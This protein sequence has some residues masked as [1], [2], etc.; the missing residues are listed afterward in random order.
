MTEQELSNLVINNVESQD[1]YDYM[2][3]NYL[4]KTN[5][6][7]LVQ[8]SPWKVYEETTL[9][10]A[11]STYTY[12]FPH[13]VKKARITIWPKAALSQTWRTITINGYTC[14]AM[15]PAIEANRAMMVT[16]DSTRE[17][18]WYTQAVLVYMN[19]PFSNG[20]TASSVYTSS[21]PSSQRSSGYGSVP[22]GITSIGTAQS[23]LLPS[24]A[25]IL[26]EGLG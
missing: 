9:A 8:G 2:R 15:N 17:D 23:A 22:N 4:I 25:Y 16:V 21:W 1:V 19:E 3:E 24:G 5:E 18:G 20:T 14:N 7:Y 13:T 11:G 10:E 6:L 12:T 26:V